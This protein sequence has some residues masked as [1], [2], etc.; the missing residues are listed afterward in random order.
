MVTG[1]AGSESD[2][3][4]LVVGVGDGSGVLDMGRPCRGRYLNL[5]SGDDVH[6]TGEGVVEF[7][8]PCLQCGGIG[9]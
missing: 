6:A 8:Q 1:V 7:H 2:A 5:P 4:L 9:R 3:G